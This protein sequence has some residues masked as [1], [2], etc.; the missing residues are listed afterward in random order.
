VEGIGEESEKTMTEK[1]KHVHEQHRAEAEA[2]AS[3]PQPE[4]ARETGAAEALRAE[5]E[6]AKAQACEY[7]DGWKRA[8]AE[9]IN[10]RK[11][12]ERDAV[13]ARVNAVGRAAARWFP[14]LDDFERALKDRV[15]ATNPEQWAEGVELI[16]RKGMAALEAEGVVPIEAAAGDS[17]DPNVHEAVTRELCAER[18]D[19][20]ILEMVH[21]GYRMGERVLRPAQVRVACK[22]ET[23]S[24][25]NP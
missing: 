11:R 7:L 1:K 18:Q 16:Y 13:D 24:Q 3:E 12:V 25:E 8:Q 15:G 4:T 17:F 22:P 10:Y 2:A 20:E 9:L 23:E 6:Q 19:G 21:R 5:L 14:V